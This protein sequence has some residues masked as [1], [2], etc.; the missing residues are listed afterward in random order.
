MKKTL[1]SLGV[2]AVLGI[3]SASA[4]ASMIN[5][6]GV[7]WDP[8]TTSAFPG[9]A[10]FT[11][12]GTVLET[13]VNPGA[14]VTHVVGRGLVTQVNSTVANST[15][16]CPGCELTYRFSMDL[17]GVTPILTNF[18][19]F[20]FTNLAIDIFVDHSADYDG[21]LAN[22][23]DGTLW[24]SLVGNGPLTGTGTDIG[25]GSDQGSG[26]ALLDVVAGG[27]ATGN[28]DTNTKLN[29]ADMVFSSSF[30]PA[31]F[32]EG[33]IPMLTGTVDLKGNSI[34]EP[35]SLALLGLGL[36]GLG[37]LQRRRRAAK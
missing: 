3:A 27:L 19:A 14:G 9:E 13:S 18:A 22:A 4:S 8:D 17:V 6:G 31:G 36:A 29:G 21:S 5:V 28:F 12:H 35:G 30:Q 16:F 26:S 7:I 10:D 20:S 15:S 24:L 32:S 2:A 25:T 34:P 11:S 33:G 1:L 37:A 23:I